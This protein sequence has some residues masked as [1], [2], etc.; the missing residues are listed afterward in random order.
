MSNYSSNP[1]LKE[2]VDELFANEILFGELDSGIFCFGHLRFGG[3]R[4]TT[5]GDIDIENMLEI[6]LRPKL[7]LRT[8]FEYR[9]LDGEEAGLT[10]EAVIRYNATMELRD[11]RSYSGKDKFRG[12]FNRRKVMSKGDYLDGFVCLSQYKFGRPI[13]K[14]FYSEDKVIPFIEED[15]SKLEELFNSEE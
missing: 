5:F 3:G 10:E 9:T 13:F 11:M 4:C 7:L 12:I 1:E 15:L 6:L 14:V 2:Y 8:P